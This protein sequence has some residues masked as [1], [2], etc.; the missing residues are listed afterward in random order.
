[1]SSVADKPH[2]YHV[3]GAIIRHGD[4]VLLVQQQGPTDA[5]PT[6]MSPGGVV[7]PGEVFSE[8]VCREVQE[9]TGLVVTQ[10]GALAYL[11]HVDDRVTRTQTIATVFEVST[12]TGTLGGR[13]PDGVVQQVAWVPLPTALARL[14]ALPWRV[15]REPALAYLTGQTPQGSSWFYRSTAPHAVDLLVGSGQT[16]SR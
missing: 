6:W 3:A 2:I 10:L 11:A 1:M 16:T 13:D 5:L 9:E 12:W 15:M 7:E 8:A 4:A 14:G